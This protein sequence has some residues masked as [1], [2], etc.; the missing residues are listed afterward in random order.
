MNAVACQTCYEWGTTVDPDLAVAF[1]TVR[2]PDCNRA[3]WPNLGVNMPAGAA[4]TFAAANAM[5]I[6]KASQLMTDQEFDNI[7]GSH[8]GKKP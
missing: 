6:A 1:F 2:C 3:T 5:H 7:L 8:R 4:W